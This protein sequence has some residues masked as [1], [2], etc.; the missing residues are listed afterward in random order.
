MLKT[1]NKMERINMVFNLF[2][3]SLETVIKKLSRYLN[4]SEKD[5]EHALRYGCS[6]QSFIEELKLN[7]CS[8]DSSN[9]NIVGRHV[10][11]AS[12]E[13]LVYFYKMGLLNL[14]QSLQET[15]PLSSFLKQHQINIDVDNHW[16]FHKDKKIAIERNKDMYHEC[17]M[18]RDSICSWTFGCEAFEKLSVLEDKLY[19]LGAT[20]EFFIAGTIEEML[21]Y[22]TV[23]RCP[24]ILDTL[25]Q[26]LN[27][28]YNKYSHCQY[29]LCC[30]WINKQVNCYIVEFE[31]N[32]SNLE[33]YNPIN[34]LEA[35]S[36]I[37]GCFSWSGITYNDYY[38]RKVPQR[39]Y[40][41]KFLIESIISVYVYNA[42]EQ[43][44]SLL[45]GLCIEPNKIKI[46]R[47]NKNKLVL[48]D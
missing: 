7:L 48:M 4:V 19:R 27:A 3:D 13:D 16:F 10:T 18:G 20:L 25:D 14:S 23:S 30:D 42:N 44:G 43:Y 6:A 22:S 41:N 26:L 37:K 29:P 24:E 12:D 46:Y 38:N 1:G 36:Q 15:T 11:T 40:D 17:F 2:A 47:V 33:T 32:L 31:S 34:Y 21:E 35:Y 8:F 28:I 9:V 5:I 39:V 45:P